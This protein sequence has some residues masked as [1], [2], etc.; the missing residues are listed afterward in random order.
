MLKGDLATEQTGMLHALS[1]C[2]ACHSIQAAC[3][4]FPVTV[5][6]AEFDDILLQ[7]LC[8]LTKCAQCM[9]NIERPQDRR[10]FERHRNSSLTQQ[11]QPDDMPCATLSVHQ[12]N[13]AE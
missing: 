5:Q 9:W 2:V 13:H 6:Q 8:L 12:S 3:S 11:Q 7:H 1:A 10:S 4:G